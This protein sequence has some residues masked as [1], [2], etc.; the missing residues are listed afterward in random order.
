VHDQTCVHA[1]PAHLSTGMADTHAPISLRQ[2]MRKAKADAAV[3]ARLTGK[4][5]SVSHD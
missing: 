5:R 2:N 4:G 3:L 1:G